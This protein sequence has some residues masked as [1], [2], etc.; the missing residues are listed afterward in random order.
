MFGLMC[1]VGE[2]E[3]GFGR[4]AEVPVNGFNVAFSASLKGTDDVW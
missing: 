4:I 2:R 3:N 1:Q